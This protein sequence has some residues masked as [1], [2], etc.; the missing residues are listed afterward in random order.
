MIEIPASPYAFKL[1]PSAIA[2]VV[3]DMQRDFVEK[4][5]FGVPSATTSH[6]S[7]RSFPQWQN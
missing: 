3:I 6:A 4:G 1:D 2:L 7:S 5:G